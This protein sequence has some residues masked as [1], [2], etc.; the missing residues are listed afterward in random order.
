MGMLTAVLLVFG[1]FSADRIERRPGGGVSLISLSAPILVL[2][3]LMCGLSAW[4]NM[5]LAPNSRLA[6]KGLMLQIRQ[7]LLGDSA[8]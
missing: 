6:Y 2:S 8:S 4:T 1:R 3:L 7:E 5:D